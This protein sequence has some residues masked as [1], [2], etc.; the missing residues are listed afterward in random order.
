VKPYLYI[1][2]VLLVGGGIGY[3]IGQK[4]VTFEQSVDKTAIDATSDEQSIKQVLGRQ[5][6][7]YRLH[8]ATLVFRD[9]SNSYVEI[10]GI[11]GETRGLQKSVMTAYQ[12]FRPGQSISLNLREIDVKIVRNSAIVRA[13]YSKTSELFEKEGIN[14]FLGSGLWLMSKVNGKWQ[15]DAFWYTEETK[16]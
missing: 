10:D 11:S 15:I 2:A 12:L 16:R 8:D 4:S 13:D 3:F 6:E 14:A 5:S 7:A 1:L 9:C